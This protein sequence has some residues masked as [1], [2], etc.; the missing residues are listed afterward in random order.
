[1]S[2]VCAHITVCTFR[3]TGLPPLV[4]QNFLLPKR[5]GE[6]HLSYA[7]WE[8]GPPKLRIIV[9]ISPPFQDGNLHLHFELAQFRQ[10]I[11]ERMY[12][13]QPLEKEGKI[14]YLKTMLSS[15]LVIPRVGC[16]GRRPCFTEDA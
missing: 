16:L 4:P 10:L 8:T 12:H 15:P 9:F 1:M 13:H 7:L 14:V 3:N 6:L 11:R 5:L 2:S